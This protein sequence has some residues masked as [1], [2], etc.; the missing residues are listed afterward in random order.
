MFDVDTLN[1]DLSIVI[2]DKTLVL[3]KSIL[4][5]ISKRGKFCRNFSSTFD[6]E[7]FESNSDYFLRVCLFGWRDCSESSVFM[8][9]LQTLR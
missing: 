7:V 8:F 1:I 9:T 4:C 2:N 6:F 5:E 3:E